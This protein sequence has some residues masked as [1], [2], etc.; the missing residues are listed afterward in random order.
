[1]NKFYLF[2]KKIHRFLALITSAM[3]IIMAGTG[4]MLEDLSSW[5]GMD[6]GMVRFIHNKLSV[7]FTFALSFMAISGIVMYFYPLWIQR[8]AKISAQNKI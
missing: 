3:I 4:L 8:K 6:L 1:M 2:S 5:F 7:S